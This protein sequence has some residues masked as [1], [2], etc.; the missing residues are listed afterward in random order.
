MSEKRFKEQRFAA[1]IRK[2]II[3]LLD[4][5]LLISSNYLACY[6][7]MNGTIVDS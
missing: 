7:T 6:I 5:V 1:L 3:A 2:V 4:I